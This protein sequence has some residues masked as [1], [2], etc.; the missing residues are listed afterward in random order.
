MVI[1][2]DREIVLNLAWQSCNLLVT[3]RSRMGRVRTEVTSSDYLF[4]RVINPE[5]GE[6]VS[7]E[8]LLSE[9]TSHKH[10]S[11]RDANI[12]ENQMV[13]L[14]LALMNM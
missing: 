2:A 1:L 3:K 7:E 14:R 12:L 6:F 8:L 4:A 11:L 13:D 10:F 5:T 9:P